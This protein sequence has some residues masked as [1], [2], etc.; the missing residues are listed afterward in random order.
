MTIASSL[1]FPD[2]RV[3]IEVPCELTVSVV[4]SAADFAAMREEW[5]RLLSSSRSD[6][7]FLTW[8]WMHTWWTH[9][10]EGRRLFLVTIR[11]GEELV[12]VAPLTLTRAWAGPFAIP[13]LEFAGTGA[14]GSDYLDFIVSAE[15]E[16]AALETL[17]RFLAETGLSLRMPRVRRQ[18]GLAVA[19]AKQLVERG[20]ESLEIQTDICPFIDLSVGS[21]EAYLGRLGP[22]HRYNFK[23]RLRNLE[24]DHTVRLHPVN[25]ETGRGGALKHLVDLHL[26]RWRNRGGSDAFHEPRLLAFHDDFSRLALERG[27]LR[28]TLLEIDGRTAGAFYG[29]RYGQVFHF[30]QSGIDPSLSRWSIGLVML[31]LTIKSAID[32]GASEY[33]MLHG[34]ESYK[35]LWATQHHPLIRIELHPPG[36]MGRVHRNAARITTAAKKLAKRVLYA[37]SPSVVAPLE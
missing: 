29:L 6:C 7:I 33:D 36:P 28:L 22:R 4:D 13:V 17:I 9:F 5:N 27:W 32:E 14:I 30:Y 31:G 37:A 24:R 12:A 34:N 11:S 23:R 19:L 2:D 8:E 16:S 10:G 20:W 1:A 15:Y 3:S 21:W 25:N 18:S 35:F 26:R